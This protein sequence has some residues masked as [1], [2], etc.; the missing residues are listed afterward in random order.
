[1]AWIEK[2][3]F[4]MASDI[5]LLRNR[6]SI[7]PKATFTG[8]M[9][10]PIKMYRETETHFGIPR[11]LYR[12][13][14]ER[15]E[16]TEFIYNIAHGNPLRVNSH[17]IKLREYDQEPVAQTLIQT[18]TAGEWGC[19]LMEAF[20][21][22]GKTVVSIEIINRLGGNALVLVH[23]EALKDQW[24]ERIKQFYPN[25][26]I[27]EVQADVCNYRDKDIVIGMVQSIMQ[28]DNGK[29]PE[30]F[31]RYFRTLVV[32]EV[33][34]MGS[35]EFGKAAP[36]FNSK[37]CFGMSGTIRRN[38]GC[39]D[40]FKWVLGDV[41]VTADESMR[42]KP[43][44]YLRETGCKFPR[45]EWD[46]IQN[47][48]LVHKTY[49]M[50]EA[51]RA[52]QLNYLAKNDA[53]NKAIAAEIIKALR[54]GRNPLVMSERKSMLETIAEYVEAFASIDP[55][56]GGKLI[57]QGFYFGG[58]SKATRKEELA[59]A[60]RCDVVYA[61]IQLAKEGIDI[62]RLETLFMASPLSDVEQLIGRICRPTIRWE[63]G[64]PVIIPKDHSAMVVDYV[65]GESS[66]FKA[67]SYKRASQYNRLGW[68]V[69]GQNF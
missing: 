51:N 49:D 40:V 23:S 26:R 2:A 17:P 14:F 7:I 33:H 53:R 45:K 68:Q 56:L 12:R 52:L 50:D 34:R 4:K 43:I 27:G 48:R 41:V 6:C 64:K 69:I 63:D 39:M 18:L 62:P 36:K 8:D 37:Y 35:H 47:G 20:T 55:V 65:D 10:R 28:D 38:D 44:V 54:T 9:I 42:V 58:K 22:F 13:E 21:A 15:K 67:L 29:Y 24:V 66:L 61:T 59:A 60:A 57:S 16:D 46:E 11:H 30:E 32:D 19:G 3:S 5:P 25:A 31:Y 1:M